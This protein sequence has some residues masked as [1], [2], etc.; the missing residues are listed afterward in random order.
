ME[1]KRLTPE[2]ALLQY[3]KHT[4]IQIRLAVEK[5]SR[6]HQTTV[7]TDVPLDG[8]LTSFISAL[9]LA[10]LSRRLSLLILP[11]HFAH[12]PTHVVDHT[13]QERLSECRNNRLKYLCSALGIGN[14]L[15]ITPQI[16]G[17]K[18][19]ATELSSPRSFV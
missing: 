2:Y 15:S 3:L 10:F 11:F 13:R 4:K 8:G 5:R 18:Q 1:I 16:R 12:P 7:G 19:P 9:L 6:V 14:L 17:V